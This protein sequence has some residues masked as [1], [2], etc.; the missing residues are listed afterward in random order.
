MHWELTGEIHIKSWCE[1]VGREALMQ[2]H[3]LAE[4]PCTF[5]HIALMPDCHVGYGMP[6]GG[7]AA[8]QDAI[9]PN[10]VGVDIGC[11]M[12]AVKTNID[13]EA[14]DY[15]TKGK[16]LI[17]SILHSIKRDVPVGFE[18]HRREQSIFLRFFTDDEIDDANQ[19]QVVKDQLQSAK[20][21]IGT[22][23]GGNHFIEIQRS[24]NDG[25]IW[26]MIHSGSRNIG[27]KIAQHF[28]KV[29]EDLCSRWKTRLPAKD[30]AFLPIGTPEARDYINAMKFAL[31]FARFN[32]QSIME[33]CMKHIGFYYA[34]Q[35]HETVF[36]DPIDVHHNFASHESH[37]GKGVWVHR[38]GATQAKDGQVG[39]IPGSM[40][41]RS[42]IVK[43]KGN[44]DSFC[45][46]SHGAG[47]TMGRA[48]FCRQ[49]TLEQA[50]AEISHIVFE[51]WGKGRKGKPD[52]SEAPSAYKN[53]VDVMDS[54]SDLVDVVDIL[55]PLGSIK[56]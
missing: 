22:L 39:I 1:E 27:Y 38:K 8:F 47:R 2:A 35:K 51:G 50:N 3:H 46:C 55:V 17:G 53:I 49:N 21:Q 37:F 4:H 29:A 41:T 42:Y 10:A 5:H 28:N 19:I 9:C 25:K 26:V 40:G 6:I 14:K 13:Y 30:L 32:R 16:E 20:H 43:G 18:H 36:E 31:Q 48:E 11:G 15:N 24:L 34:K 56:G 23:G 54:Q 12:C 33:V 7:I 44:A 45:S 52:Y